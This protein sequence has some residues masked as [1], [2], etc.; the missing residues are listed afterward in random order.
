MHTAMKRQPEGIPVG[1][2]F[3]AS[4]HAEPEIALRTPAAPSTLHAALDSTITEYE[5][6]L[7]RLSVDDTG[8][9]SEANPHVFDPGANERAVALA[10]GIRRIEVLRDAGLAEGELF[11]AVHGLG[12]ELRS[13]GFAD[14]D[15]PASTT[16]ESIGNEL[17]L[18]AFDN[19]DPAALLERRARRIQ[20]GAGLS[21]E[22]EV[23]PATSRDHTELLKY[24]ARLKLSGA[25]G[26][27]R[28]ARISGEHGEVFDASIEN[29]DGRRFLLEM[30]HS[31][32]RIERE[33]EDLLGDEFIDNATVVVDAGPGPLTP[34]MLG[35]A[36]TESRRRSAL[37]DAWMKSTAM[38]STPAGSHP[39]VQFR[40]FSV[41]LDEDVEAA[42]VYAQNSIG[43]YRI[44]RLRDPATGEAE[45]R[46]QPVLNEPG[47][48]GKVPPRM[49]SAILADLSQ[50]GGGHPSGAAFERD[51]DKA[52]AAAKADPAVHPLG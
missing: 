13:R 15:S 24:T 34:E 9:P 19:R 25:T 17:I 40:D 42:V 37:T 4:V 10:E 7:A 26:T 32:L 1:G 21:F 46:V 50:A 12:Q 16:Y 45:T 20:A 27:V 41:H 38:R 5:R 29:P 8:F 36:L 23:L 35:E 44:E 14:R 3:A 31:N 47:D 30:S 48:E 28:H 18:T 49:T 39:A 43:S 11:S 2:Q 51:L 22:D 52:L 33:D 6:R